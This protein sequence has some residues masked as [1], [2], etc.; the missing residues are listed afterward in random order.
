MYLNDLPDVIG[1]EQ[2]ATYADDTDVVMTGPDWTTYTNKLNT[3]LKKH[4]DFLEHR[5]MG[6]QYWK[7]GAY[8]IQWT[9][10]F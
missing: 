1:A 2:T 8:S 4:L 6:V 10:R 7:D 9:T 3:I 5:G